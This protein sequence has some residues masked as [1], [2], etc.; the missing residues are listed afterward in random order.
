MIELGERRLERKIVA[1]RVDLNSSVNVSQASQSHS[2]SN[3]MISQASSACS[4]SERV[5]PPPIPPMHERSMSHDP[6]NNEPVGLT[7]QMRRAT[8]EAIIN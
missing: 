4:D 5:D 6:E 8:S 2:H 3:I 7:L 1:P